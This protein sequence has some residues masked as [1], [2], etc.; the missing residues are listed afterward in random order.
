M[1]KHRHLVALTLQIAWMPSHTNSQKERL[2][3]FELVQS[4]WLKVQ[5]VVLLL[6][7]WCLEHVQPIAPIKSFDLDLFFVMSQMRKMQFDFRLGKGDFFQI[8]NRTLIAF[9]PKKQTLVDHTTTRNC[10]SFS[11]NIIWLLF[12]TNCLNLRA[13]DLLISAF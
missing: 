13:A 11:I 1:A 6:R 4:D 9:M 7:L 8:R 12:D 2:P 5:H 3:I 10:W